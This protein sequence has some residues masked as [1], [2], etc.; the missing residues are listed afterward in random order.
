MMLKERDQR[1]Q[2]ARE[3]ALDLERLTCGEEPERPARLSEET[4]QRKRL[5]LERRRDLRNAQSRLS[6]WFEQVV[7]AYVLPKAVG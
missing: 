7:P 1:Y 3:V 2:T 6:R 4:R 5:E